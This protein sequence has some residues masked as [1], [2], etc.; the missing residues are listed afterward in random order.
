LTFPAPEDALLSSYRFE[1]DPGRIAQ[2]PPQR[3]GDSRLLVVNRATGEVHH[4]SF[5]GLDDFLAPG[6]LLVLNDSRVLPARLW[7][8]K[9]TGGRVEILLLDSLGRTAWSAL[10]RPSARVR[11]GTE[12]TV[13][14]RGEDWR[15]PK[16]LIGEAEGEGTRRVEGVT[17]DLLD[18]WGEMPLPPY[19]DRSDGPELDDRSR[20]Q[21][22]YARCDGS[23]AAP[24][25]GLHFTERHLDRLADRGVSRAHVTLHVGAGTFAPLRT[26]RLDEAE[27]HEEYYCVPTATAEAASGC[28]GRLVA[29]GTTGCR[30]LESWHRVGRP[31]DGA[32]RPTRLF[33]H[34]GDP[35][36]LPMSLLTN[37]HLPGGSLVTLVA[38]FLGRER[39]LEL[40]RQA[41]DL[42]YRFY[43][44]GDAMLIL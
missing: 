30:T 18:C 14:R 17:G 39:T 11:P 7:A 41:I 3:R 4:G 15:G 40:Y 44:Y 36:R 25:A 8:R 5:D 12:V 27:L 34:P 43:S 23:V 1:L 22:V 2:H 10:V 21:T 13:F 26:E 24:T 29:V 16:L 19:I 32:L 37:F 35:P 28:S 9:P 33:L 6:D 38:A 42:D 20:Y 31:E